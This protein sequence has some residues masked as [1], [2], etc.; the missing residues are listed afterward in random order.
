MDLICQQTVFLTRYIWVRIFKDPPNLY[1][2]ILS[3]RVSPSSPNQSRTLS[4][5]PHPVDYPLNSIAYHAANKAARLTEDLR[6][7]L[8]PRKG[9]TDSGGVSAGRSTSEVGMCIRDVWRAR[10][11]SMVVPLAPSPGPAR[12]ETLRWL[13]ARVRLL[14]NE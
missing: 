7:C 12:W 13:F 11:R 3:V 8:R 4:T 10:N 6:R 9:Q 5:P 14:C 2:Q 1:I